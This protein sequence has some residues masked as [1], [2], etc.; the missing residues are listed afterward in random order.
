MKIPVRREIIFAVVL[1]GLLLLWGVITVL[2]NQDDHQVD[3]SVQKTQ[4]LKKVHYQKGLIALKPQ[5]AEDLN[6]WQERFGKVTNDGSEISGMVKLVEQQA[7]NH[8]VHV[9]NVQPRRA[10]LDGQMKAFMIEVTLD[11][12]WRDVNDFIQE[13]QMNPLDMDIE[14]L[15]LERYSDATNSLRGVVVFKRWRYSPSSKG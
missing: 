10:V 2:K 11:G 3:L 8:N 9:V 1:L 14:S 7:A 6:A 12:Q 15:Q 4:A 13:L 5:V